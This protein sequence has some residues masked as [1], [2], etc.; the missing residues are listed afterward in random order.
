MPNSGKQIQYQQ[1][2]AKAA[3]AF[4]LPQGFKVVSPYPFGGMDQQSSRV[5]LED[6]EFYNLEN[7]IKIGN[8]KLRTLWDKGSAIY[9]APTGKTI[10]YFFFYNIGANNYALVFLSDGTAVQVN[11]STSG[12][13]VVSSV[14]NTFY[15]GGQLPCC[16]QW[17]S[18]YLLIANNITPNS[19]W[20][21]GGSYLYAPGSLGP[22][23]TLTASGSGYTSAPTVTAFGGEGSGITAVATIS[24]GSVVL[25]TLTNPGS[26]YLPSDI[27]QFAFSGGGGNNSAILTASLT[28]GVVG[29]LQLLAGGSGFTAGTYPLTFTGGGGTGAAGTYTVVGAAVTSLDL[30]AGGS[31]YTGSPIITF[32]SGGGTGAVALA[33]LN[34]GTVASVTVVNGGTGFTS[35]PTLTFESGG[36]TGGAATAVLTSGSI[37]S[38]SVTAGGS[39]YTTAPA[40][41]VQTGVNTAAAAIGTLMPFGVS[42]SSIE[43][44]Q[45]RVWLAFPNQTGNQENGG[46]FLV[47]A[48]GSLTDY[49]TSDGG[50]TYT[51]TDSFLRYQYTNLKQSNGYLY[52]IG[53]SSVDVISN[54]QT[55]GNPSAT[56][57]NYQNT[58]PQVGTSWRDTVISFSRTILLANPM[59]VYGLY[60]GSVTKISGKMDDLFT[61]AVLPSAGGTTPC[62]AVANIFSQKIYLMLLTI[63]DLYTNAPRTVM[64]SWNEK[65]WFITSQSASLTFIGTQEVNSNLTA[66]GTEGKSLFPLF[67]SPSSSL[68]KRLSTKLYGAQAGFIIKQAL[69]LYVEAADNT[70]SGSGISFSTTIDTELGGFPTP[71][72]VTFPS[73]PPVAPPQTPVFSMQSGDAYGVN[74]GVTLTSTSPDFSLNNLIL[75]YS[76]SDGLFGSTNLTGYSGE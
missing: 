15:N 69:A 59:G 75:G 2:S 61:N 10:V 20:I 62:A 65:E 64:I 3:E 6:N 33:N 39:G 25:V 44:Y 13:T 51:S 34:P 4:G 14:A 18:L 66:W 30:T 32:P 11:S 76:D 68:T 19:Y 12:I 56:T 50:L 63:R 7:Y 21:W 52:P 27:V 23:V 71:N 26:G 49:A 54:V 73:Q 16:T 1:L 48:P 72:S 42:G 38:V 67:N 47:S 35:T 22:G 29:S 8:G 57:F 55:S 53:D 17:G 70:A 5:A 36:G 46:T 41:I 24:N 74:L 28:V 37:T 9:T 45:Q 60:G 31:G 40:V 43:T 58:D